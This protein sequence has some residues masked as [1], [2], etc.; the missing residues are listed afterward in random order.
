MRSPGWTRDLGAAVSFE[1]VV[2][3]VEAWVVDHVMRAD[4]Q[5]A[6]FIRER[7]GAA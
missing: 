6:D 5:L 4:H 1:A 2:A 7:R 3:T